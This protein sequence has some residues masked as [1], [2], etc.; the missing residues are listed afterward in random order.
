ML[1]VRPKDLVILTQNV[2]YTEH[3]DWF[4]MP[5]C[6]YRNQASLDKWPVYWGSECASFSNLKCQNVKSSKDN[7]RGV[8]RDIVD[9]LK[10]LL[11][12]EAKTIWETSNIILDH[13]AKLELSMNTFWYEELI[14]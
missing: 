7:D 3:P 14:E 12:A 1:S 10:E 2:K 6:N 5:F 9:N 8:Q 4:P 11:M 13:N